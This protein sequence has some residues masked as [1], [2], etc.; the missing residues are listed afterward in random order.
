MDKEAAKH[1]HICKHIKSIHMKDINITAVLLLKII[2]WWC[3]G[4][5]EV[6]KVVVEGQKCPVGLPKIQL[7]SPLTKHSVFTTINT[8]CH[9]CDL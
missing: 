8:A 7:L 2:C 1:N 6:Q 4:E 9:N 3:M 5:E